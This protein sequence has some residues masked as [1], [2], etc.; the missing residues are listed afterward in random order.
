M[1]LEALPTVRG[2][3]HGLAENGTKNHQRT[4]WDSW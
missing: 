1:T 2:V 4:I 3:E